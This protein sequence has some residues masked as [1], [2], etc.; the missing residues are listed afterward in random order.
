MCAP[1]MLMRS[2]RPTLRTGVAAATGTVS[3]AC[4]A[5]GSKIND[6]PAHQACSA[7]HFCKRHLHDYQKLSAHTSAPCPQNQA[8]L[9]T[10]RRRRST[11]TLGTNFGPMLG[12]RLKC[13]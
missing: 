9:G 2:K 4:S 3:A 6:V 1:L 13:V 8:L 7:G 10:G 5:T 12:H 11:C